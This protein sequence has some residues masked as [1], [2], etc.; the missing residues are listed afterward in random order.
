MSSRSKNKLQKAKANPVVV[1]NK[2]SIAEMEKRM[3][4]AKTDS[5]VER[6]LLASDDETASKMDKLSEQLNNSCE[7]VDDSIEK[8]EIPSPARSSVSTDVAQ[9]QNQIMSMLMG[10]KKDQFTKSEFSKFDRK[11]DNKF[12]A[13]DKELATHITQFIEMD[14]RVSVVEQAMADAAYEK[15]LNKQMALKN[16]ISIFGVPMKSGELVSAIALEVLN[17]FDCKLDANSISNAYRSVGRDNK[18]PSIIIKFNS[19]ETKLKALNAKKQVTL[20]DVPSFKS[21]KSKEPIY[22]NNHATPYFGRILA[23]GRRAVKEK[24]I[25][26]CWIGAN[27]CLIKLAE[28][29]KPQCV[30]SCAMLVELSSNLTD[31]T[32]KKRSKPDDHSSPIEVNSKKIK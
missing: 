5:D 15:E 11:L 27:G 13:V 16:N 2:A 23:L 17:A 22:I 30:K 6:E 21:D 7:L 4:D 18:F 32:K 25:H 29:D 3:N 10:I 31:M 8:M 9:N 26:S 14:S 1:L 19:F 12:K 24:R 28:N 20:N